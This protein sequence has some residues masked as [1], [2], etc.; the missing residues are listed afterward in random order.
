MTFII[1]DQMNFRHLALAIFLSI[2]S[3]A[4]PARAAAKKSATLLPFA[5]SYTGTATSSTSS[6]TMS[7]NAT[8][9]FTGRGG[10]LRGT[11][12]YTGI[13]GNNGVA[14]TVIQTVNTTGTGVCTGRVILDGINGLCSGQVSL[15]GKTLSF[16]LTYQLADASNTTITLT[17]TV[18][19]HSRKATMS[20]TVTS[21]TDAGYNGTLSVTGK[22]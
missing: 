1:L 6:G 14:K 20:A 10:N 5:G 2:V 4:C 17:G 18:I 15:H 8:L 12:L 13:L 3:L 19:F 9:T 11:F 16:T 22:R 21:P 7:G